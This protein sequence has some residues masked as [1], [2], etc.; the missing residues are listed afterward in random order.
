[1]MSFLKNISILA[2]S[3]LLL[4]NCQ[5]SSKAPAESD[6]ATIQQAQSEKTKQ[7]ATFQY[8][9]ENPVPLVSAHRGGPYPG[10]P[11]NAIETFENIVNQTPA[12][13]ECDVSITKD[14]VLILMHD[15][16]LVRTT[17]GSGDVTDQLYRDIESLKLV[18][19]DG[20]PTDYK[21]PTLDRVLEWGNG[22]AL[23]TLDVKRGVPFEKVIEAIEQYDA[24]SYAA[25]ITYRIQDAILVHSLNP[26]IMISVSARD[27]GALDQIIKSEIP[28]K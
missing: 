2:L 20:N 7:I 19:N 4:W 24:E 22:K 18:D 21:I 10:Y 28:A 3:V 1:M 12:V 27:D 8:W 6:E 16:T 13:I 9:L 15:K 26:N 11:E 25:I 14:G 23:F 17:D 5:P